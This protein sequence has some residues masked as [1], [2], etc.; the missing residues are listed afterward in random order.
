MYYGLPEEALARLAKEAQIEERMN[1]DGGLE[2]NYGVDISTLTRM[3]EAGE[4]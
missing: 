4:I 1:V 2:V 3:I